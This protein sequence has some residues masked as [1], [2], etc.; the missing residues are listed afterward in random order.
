VR[1]LALASALVL[2]ASGCGGGDDGDATPQPETTASTT[3][4]TTPTTTED[5]TSE[6]DVQL[7]EAVIANDLEEARRLLDAGANPNTPDSNRES[8]F[9]HASSELGPSPAM[10]ELL[11][12]NGADVNA[13][14][15]NNSTA[16][17]RAAQ[18]GYPEL[19]GPLI[20]ADA[21][22]DHVNDLNF[23]AVLATVIF[24]DGSE[25]YVETVRLLV[26][27]GA[28]ATIPD[29]HGT[30]PLQHAQLAGQTK[31]AAVLRRAI[32]PGG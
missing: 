9:L 15:A 32:R 28:D 30:P 2:L 1:A 23:T 14:D 17:I 18:R 26:D 6:L 16:L 29:V 19:V 3:A 8:A 13:R 10:L 21:D 24:G 11:L 12:E 7:R 25:P 22:L 20:E 4:A 31:V 27:G 5:E